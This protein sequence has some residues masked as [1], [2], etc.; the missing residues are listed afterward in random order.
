[1]QRHAD[2]DGPAAIPVTAPSGAEPTDLEH[3]APVQRVADGSPATSAPAGAPGPTSPAGPPGPVNP[4][5]GGRS[6]IRRRL[7]EPLG[8]RPA[9]MGPESDLPL[10]AVSTA[11]RP[12]VQRVATVPAPA[13]TLPVARR[14]AAVAPSAEVGPTPAPAGFGVPAGAAPLAGLRSIGLQRVPEDDTPA[15][16]PELDADGWPVPPPPPPSWQA[17]PAKPLLSSVG[18]IPGGGGPAP[19]PVRRGVQRVAVDERVATP[20]VPG[21]GAPLGIQRVPD[22]VPSDLAEDLKPMLGTDVSRVPVHRGPEV[23]EAATQ[24]Q[25]KAF[26]SG[27]EVHMP[28]KLGPTSAGEGR[29]VLAHELTHTVQQQRLGSSLPSEETAEGQT[30]EN[31]AKQVAGALEVP[32]AQ[33][34]PMAQRLADETLT[35]PSSRIGSFGG[36][37]TL[38]GPAAFAMAQHVQRAALSGGLAMA[39]PGAAPGVSFPTPTLPVDRGGP[40]PLGV[41]RAVT[42]NEVSTS[43]GGGGGAS[44]GSGSPTQNEASGAKSPGDLDQLANDLYGRIATRLR[45]DLLR[46][47]ERAGRLSD[48]N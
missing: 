14:I 35:H 45:R 11:P 18:K 46:Q 19:V 41:Q 42:I 38:T 16:P 28:E 30:L 37:T 12:G 23:A 9:T 43:V 17:E 40:V 25:A 8:Q 1:V 10:L 6:V 44:P 15:G 39:T 22:S 29:A 7:G 27:G 5:V 24:L 3:V 32:K 21:G 20:P 26:T 33:R 48:L 47:R 34:L 36:P 31:E 2:H 4:L 13:S